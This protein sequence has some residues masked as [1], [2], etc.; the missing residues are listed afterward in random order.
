MHTLFTLFSVLLVVIACYLTLGMLRR[1][2]EW[3]S[4]RDL[5]LWALG[6]P[7]LS[8]VLGIGALFHFA[9]QDCFFSAPTWDY[10]LAIIVP[11]S[12]GIIAFGSTVFG[13][14]RLALISWFVAHRSIEPTPELQR[15][16]NRQADKL[17]LAH[18]RLL[19]SIHNRPLALTCGLWRPTLLLST[20][21][22]VHLDRQE[23]E[24]VLAHELAHVVRHDCF[25]VLLATILRD[26]FFYLPTTRTT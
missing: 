6:L 13:L 11:S 7:L 5:Q 15:L 25:A 12:M 14:G 24:S 1:T 26:A 4:R 21:M 10:L 22:I 2:E 20:W 3:T 18:P 19:L 23:L 9:Y 17:G 8:L 16:A